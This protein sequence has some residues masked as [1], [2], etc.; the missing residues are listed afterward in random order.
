MTGGNRDRRRGRERKEGGEWNGDEVQNERE[1][2][3]KR[4]EQ[5]SD[6]TEER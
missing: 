2:A 3:K 1:R 6:R 5:R 4:E